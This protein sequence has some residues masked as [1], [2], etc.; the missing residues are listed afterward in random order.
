M[1]ILR[2]QLRIGV[3]GDYL[4]WINVIKDRLKVVI[5]KIFVVIVFSF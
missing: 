3:D 4:F 5:I 2:R 1:E